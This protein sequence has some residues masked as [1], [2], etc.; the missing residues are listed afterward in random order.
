MKQLKC[1]N[2]VKA[3]ELPKEFLSLKISTPVLAMEFCSGGDLRK[4]LN[5]PQNCCGVEE[6]EVRQILK[7]VS[8]AIEYLHSLNIIHRDL[9]P[10]N[11]V[12]QPLASG[13]IL[14]KL[15]DLGYAKQLSES[16]FANSFV[17]TLE[18]LAPELFLRVEY[19]SAVDNWSFGLLAYE[20]ITGR[21]PFLPHHSMADILDALKKKKSTDICTEVDELGNFYFSSEISPINNICTTLKTDLESW[22]KVRI[23]TGCCKCC[24]AYLITHSRLCSSMI[25]INAEV[26]VH[27]ASLAI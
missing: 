19:S 26:N 4:V 22:L 6:K 3:L 18:Y 17:G 9:K 24:I 1:E 5:K 12:L 27:F 15:T 20:I 16:T 25:Q 14:Y 7:Q 21:R 8:S 2:V 11:I 23:A 13:K 10:E